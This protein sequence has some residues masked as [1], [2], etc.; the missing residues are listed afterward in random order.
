MGFR[1]GAKKVEKEALDLS[2]RMKRAAEDLI[3]YF[4]V[5]LPQDEKVFRNFTRMKPENRYHVVDITVNDATNFRNIPPPPHFTI[6][7]RFL[8]W[9]GQTRGRPDI[10]SHE[11]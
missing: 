5:E 9:L 6:F 10:A 7:T 11:P 2:F 8:S 1:I 3:S 4:M